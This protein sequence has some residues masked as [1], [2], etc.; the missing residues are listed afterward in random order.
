MKRLALPLAT[1]I[2]ASC[3]TS[4]GVTPSSERATFLHPTGLPRVSHVV[5]IIQENRTLDDMFNGF[6]G[7]NT[8]TSG[9]NTHGKSVPLAPIALAAPYDMSHK[10]SMW[11]NE[12]DGGKMDGF[13]LEAVNC[14]AKGSQCP[15]DNVAAYGYVPES[16]VEPYWSL[17][18]QYVLADEMFE[19]SEGPS[20]PAHQYLVSGTSTIS[21]GSNYRA[22]SNAYDVR[23]KSRQGGC[24]S[25]KTALVDTV[26]QNGYEGNPVYPCFTRLSLMGSTQRCRRF[27]ALLSGAARF[28]R[29][30]RPRRDQADMERPNVQER[31]LAVVAGARRY[32]E[33]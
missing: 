25:I 12:Y 30:A 11:N 9:E 14:Y 26:D 16:Q 13:N 8:V 17:G 15:P 2:L 18:Q 24:D 31:R 32:L 4:A 1:I 20:F 29:M 27:V 22:S 21:E 3:A 33:R 28:R 10:Y 23:N 7:A 19:T 6:P 5:F